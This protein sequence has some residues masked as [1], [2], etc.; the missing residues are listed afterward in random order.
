MYPVVV[1]KV[2]CPQLWYTKIF[3]HSYGTQRQ[4]GKPSDSEYKM[5]TL[6]SEHS[7]GYI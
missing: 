1:H 3:V 5:I 2:C 7:P 6:H 4:L